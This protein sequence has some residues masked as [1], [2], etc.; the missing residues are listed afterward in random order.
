VPSSQPA[1]TV[2]AQNPAAGQKAPQGSAVRV[3]VSKG[4]SAT[5]TT[6]AP[7]ATTTSGAT[8]P[9]PPASGN[10]YT[11]MRLSQAVQ[12]IAQGR[13]QTIVTYATS[14]QPAGVVVSNSKSGSRV[15]LQVSAG[16]HPKPARDVPDVGGEDRATA[17]QDLQAAG[18]TVLE[19][20]WPVSDQSQ[21]GTVVYET[22]S[23]GEQA[24]GGSA[25][26][27]YIGTVNG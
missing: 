27:I 26:V 21:D 9:A 15:Q 16:A 6:T 4:K 20:Q 23:G 13:Q 8:T 7:Q 14:S 25:I 3:N 24:P 1:G 22:P 12:K 11:G 5:T 18:F 17:E 10:D 19:V 2:V